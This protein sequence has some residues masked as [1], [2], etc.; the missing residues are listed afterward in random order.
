MAHNPFQMVLKMK[1]YPLR[2]SVTGKGNVFSFLWML[3]PHDEQICI[4]INL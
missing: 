1:R 4:T 3:E 2:A